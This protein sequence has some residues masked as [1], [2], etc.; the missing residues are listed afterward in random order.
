MVK[1]ETATFGAGCFWQVELLFS[2]TKGVVKTRV[3]YM[4][5]DE[6]RYSSPEYKDVCTDRTGH[7]EVVQIEFDPKKVS[8]TQLL[9]LFWKNHNPTTPNRQGPDV[10]TQYRSVIFFHN[11]KQKE[12]ALKSMKETQK[13]FKNKIVTLIIRAPVFHP[14]EEYHQNYLKK[15]GKTRC[16]V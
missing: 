4:G 9:D 15:Q 11:T 16:Y 7:T 3:G 2:E 8:Y 13:N 6:E 14:A 12:E 1:T 10:G 5:G